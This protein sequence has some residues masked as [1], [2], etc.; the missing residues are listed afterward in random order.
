[1]GFRE[2]R[3]HLLVTQIPFILKVFQHTL[4]PSESLMWEGEKKRGHSPQSHPSELSLLPT[5]AY[6]P[7]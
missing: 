1:M 2:E 7:F 4:L 6:P 5:A 3:R